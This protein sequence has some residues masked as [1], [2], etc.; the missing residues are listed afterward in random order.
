MQCWS[1]NALASL[2]WRDF[3]EEWAVFDVASGQTHWL[4]G[5]SAAV[6]MRF[7]DGSASLADIADFTQTLGV[8]S[9]DGLKKQI[10]DIVSH[11]QSIGLLELAG[12]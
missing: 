4:D 9:T 8:Q 12:S 10:T 11:L 6:L 3:G 1:L 7:Q 2:H 5:L